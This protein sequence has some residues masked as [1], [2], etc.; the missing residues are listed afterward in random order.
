MKDLAVEEEL[1]VFVSIVNHLQNQKLEQH[2]FTLGTSSNS[3]ELQYLH[4]K[5]KTAV[6]ERPHTS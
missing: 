3:Y 6:T 2:F 4:V 5:I 1:H